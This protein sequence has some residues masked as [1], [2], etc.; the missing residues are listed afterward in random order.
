VYGVSRLYTDLVA[1]YEDVKVKEESLALAQKLYSDTEAQV[2]EGTLARVEMT[3]A[4]A[5][6]FS[7][8]QD[9]I[10]SRGLL[11][12]QEAI[13]K[14]VLSKT[15]NADPQLQTARIIPTDSLSIPEKQETRPIQ[16]FLSEAMTTRP[17]LRQAGLQIDNSEIGL[18]GSRNAVLPQVDLVGV[19]QNNGLAGTLNPLAPGSDISLVGGYGS[20][21]DQVFTRKFPTYG[22][23]VQV[24]LPLRNRIAQADL[25][26]DE[27]QL[28]QSQIR[29]RQLQ[30]QARLEIEDALIAMRRARASSEAAVQARVL[31]QESLEA[32]QSKFEVGASTSFFVIQYESLV[33]QAKSTE[34]A[35]KSAYV[36]ARSALQRAT[37]TILSDNQISI[38]AAFQNHK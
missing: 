10:N 5:S 17:D 23:G 2:Q 26:R 33:A 3:R 4:N 28:R 13:L 38:E 12:E 37:G 15:G 36:K 24:T 19:A 32:E 14:T 8:R 11:E 20:A 9:L 6:V 30:N 18:K 22:I 7:T 16:D 35:A 27:I 34:V 31:Q 1:L 21:L 29:L 25:A